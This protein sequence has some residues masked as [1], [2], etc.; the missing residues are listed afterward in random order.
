MMP[1]PGH[2]IFLRY[3]GEDGA[4][5]EGDGPIVRL[6]GEV[7]APGVLCD[8]M[9]LVA[10]AGWKGE[11]V[12]VNGQASRSLFFETGNILGGQT[13][14]VGERLGALL[15]RLGVLTSA[16]LEIIGASLGE[17]RK[18]GEVA[19]ERGFITT[20]KLFEVIVEQTK[21]IA[22][23]TLLVDDGMFYFLDRYDPARIAMQHHVSANNVLMEGVQRM[24]ESKY[25]R[26]RIPSDNHIPV[27]I[28]G[29]SDPEDELKKVWD[30]C[31]GRRSVLEIGRV[32][33]LGEFDVTRELFQL[34]RTGFLHISPPTPE[35]PEA[36]VDIF[37][38]AMSAIYEAVG[39]AGKGEL[40]RQHLSAFATSIGIYDTLF[41]GA[42]PSERGRLDASR[43]AHN[44]QTLGGDDPDTV[45]AQWLYEYVAFA[46][47]DG[48]S[49]LSKD[50]EQLLSKYVSERIQI[51]APKT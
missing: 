3:V 23:A 8:I 40:L 12:V 48:G 4:R 17:G 39:R 27:P 6:A 45:L 1:A 33:G 38:D 42:G 29:R 24:D 26:E 9:A 28:A 7:T 14:V 49:Q 11:L 20:E 16:Q 50:E 5:D 25:F 34:V 31:D 51:L 44:I 21:E 41:A 30:A 10:Q 36:L 37:N 15:Y 13:N 2:V 22:F 43:I 47:F 18:F 32:C 19:V 46:L 35:G